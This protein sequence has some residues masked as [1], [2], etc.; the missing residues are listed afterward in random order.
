MNQTLYIF[1]KDTRRFWIEILISI[2]LLTAFAYIAPI[3]SESRSH[4]DDSLLVLST[5]FQ[6][7]LYVL[8]PVSWWILVSRVVHEENLVGDRQFWIT[9]PYRWPNLLS[10][11]VLFLVAYILLPIGLMQTAIIFTSGLHPATHI[12]GLLF[13]VALLGTLAILPLYALSTVT[14]S[15]AK[16]TLGPVI[17]LAIVLV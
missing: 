11:K 13:S 10:A 9:R 7:V 6:T 15:F 5:I 4:R 14:A 8:I 3:V 1:A 16:L 2:A 12:F 17:K